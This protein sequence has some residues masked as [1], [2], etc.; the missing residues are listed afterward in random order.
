LP[1]DVD[2]LPLEVE[3]L[4]LDVDTLPLE[5]ETLPLDV[6]TF[7]LD[8]D[9]PEVEVDPP[10]VDVDVEPVLVDETTTLP[11]PPLPPKKPPK[12][13]PPKPPT[14]PRRSPPAR[15]RC[16]PARSGQGACRG[17]RHGILAGWLA[18]RRGGAATILRWRCTMGRGAADDPA[19]LGRLGLDRLDV[20]DFAGRRCLGDMHGAAAQDRAPAAQAASFANAIRTDM[21]V[22]LAEIPGWP[23]RS[24]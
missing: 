11:P 3:T 10:E 23:S 24:A 4:P 18:G 20:V 15:R 21:I 7:P 6:E 17:W 22:A 8:V 14:G 1:L 9:P 13:P 2:T 5:V 16:H 12:K 19:R